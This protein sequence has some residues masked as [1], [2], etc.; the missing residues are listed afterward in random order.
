MEGLAI[1]ADV[2]DPCGALTVVSA[3]NVG[4]VRRPV[5]KD[6]VFGAISGK[7]TILAQSRLPVCQN[8][9]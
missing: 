4:V 6:S 8:H 7:L 2:T 9:H 5:A 3:R 1:G